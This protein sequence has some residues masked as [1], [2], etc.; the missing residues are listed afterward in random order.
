MSL[1]QH[2]NGD[3]DEDGVEEETE[4]QMPKQTRVSFHVGLYST[5]SPMG[6]GTKPGM[7]NPMPF[8]Q[9]PMII[10]AQAALNHFRFLPCGR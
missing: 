3:T 9:M 8:V 1:R 10:N 6:V 4:A 5:I 2:G 7:I